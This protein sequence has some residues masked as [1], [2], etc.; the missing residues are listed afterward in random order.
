MD[1]SDDLPIDLARKTA[2]LRRI[3]RGILFEPSLADD[4]VQEAWLAALRA[5][6]RGPTAGGWLTNAVR[7]IALGMR[8]GEA[9]REKRD[10]AAA[11]TEAL[12]PAN[13]T[14]E[15]IELLRSILDALQA[16]DEPYKTALQLRL[17]DDLDAHAIAERLDIP[18]ET[19]RTR[20][21]RG[22]ALLRAR[23]DAQNAHRRNEFLALLAPLA[24]LGHV[25]WTVGTLGG[26]KTI[27]G[28][29]VGTKAKLVAVACV[30]LALGAW[31]IRPWE[32]AAT[33]DT[34]LA[35]E[36]TPIEAPKA[37]LTRATAND[38]LAPALDREST[39]RTRDARLAATNANAWH[40]RARAVRGGNEPFPGAS[41]HV[42]IDTGYTPPGERAFDALVT[43]GADGWFEV[44]LPEPSTA[45]R[46]TLQGQTPGYVGFFEE[47]LVVRGAPPPEGLVA[48]LYP[49]D[50]RL[51]GSVLD[52]NGAP[53]G[54]AKLV[55]RGSETTADGSGHFELHASSLLRDDHVQVSAHGFA[56]KRVV[57]AT[58]GRSF[59]DDLEIRLGPG[60]ALR[61]RVVDETGAP[62][63]GAEVEGT[64][65]TS[66]RVRS[67][68]SGRFVL[69]GLSPDETWLSVWIAAEGHAGLRRDFEDGKVPAEEVEFVLERG[70]DVPGVVVDTDGRP[71]AGASVHAGS[72]PWEM[73]TVRT[74]SDDDGRFV[75]RCVPRATRGFGVALS[76]FAPF[77]SSF[78][79]PMQG[80]FPG[81]LRA[82]L[83]R[84]LVVKGVVEDT[85]GAPVANVYVSGQ[86]GFDY[87][88]GVTARTGAD[89][90]FELAAVPREPGVRLEFYRT[91]YTRQEHRLDVDRNPLVRIVLER[92]AGLSGRVVDAATGAP[93]TAFRVRIVAPEL[94]P[95]EERLSS[96][97]AV[98]SDPGREVRDELGRWTMDQEQVEAGSVAGIEITAAGYGPAIV[99]RAIATVDHGDA[100]IVISMSAAAR[101]TGR[102]VDAASGAPVANALVR[103]FTPRDP[104]GPWERYSEDDRIETRTDERGEFALEGLAVEPM[105]LFVESTGFAPAC[106]G[107]FEVG[108]ATA[109][110]KV[111]LHP[112]A[113][114]RGV[115]K[116]SK[117]EPIANAPVNVD[118]PPTD[119]LASR[120]WDLV[121]DAQGR[122]ELVDLACGTYDVTRVL[123]E[124]WGAMHD[125]SQRVEVLEARAYDVEL[126]PRGAT[127]LIGRLPSSIGA[128]ASFTVSAQ[129]QGSERNGQSLWRG[130]VAKNGR[131]ELDGLEPGRWTVML[132][133]SGMGV[134]QH[135]SGRVEV[136]VPASG[137]VTVDVD[138]H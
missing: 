38:D 119:T 63:A 78:E 1:R 21:K 42:V 10:R 15:R 45:L 56:E 16:L 34:P 101:V 51:R 43:S 121:T 82:V 54:G 73:N 27:G 50:V 133:E 105:S 57:V 39:T 46:I 83:D 122:F 28:V 49:L 7:N 35:R 115:L 5:D 4:A 118:R 131:F 89:G 67:D 80:A 97:A 72:S 13:D 47:A 23:L 117:G 36:A 32:D 3:A 12:P 8:R 127:T 77:V 90:V 125:L 69:E 137:T 48:R 30:V 98:W 60:A 11:R 88:D 64:N 111:E 110:R 31:W 58:Q 84:G 129:L 33:T 123:P 96:Y 128:G 86:R 24:G 18:L 120:D 76:G 107:P 53:I 20:V 112:G 132:F 52:A 91:G 116:D 92:S 26:A 130:A 108:I 17:V 109:A 74:V 136:D 102:V 2:A 87:L 71:L 100:P 25:G 85:R 22:L 93:V 79:L 114:L 37:E 70:V 134:P 9:R 94:K 14:V 75:L 6:V 135:R 44:A 126:R 41:V 106:D 124:K 61:G 40:L 29:L 113:T 104:G 19:A 99:P 103:R 81:E 59:V 65:A 55:G 62:V 138:V 68:A 95:G 66:S